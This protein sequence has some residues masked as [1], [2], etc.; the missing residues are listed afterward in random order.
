[1]RAGPL[2]ESHR[3]AALFAPMVA[4]FKHHTRVIRGWV[5]CMSS[6]RCLRLISSTEERPPEIAQPCELAQQ[7]LRAGLLPHFAWRHCLISYSAL[8]TTVFQRGALGRGVQAQ[9]FVEVRVW[10]LDLSM[11]RPATACSSPPALSCPCR[12]SAARYPG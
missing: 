8:A 4:V 6:A 2:A 7:L 10:G 9:V 3:R 12:C 1:M 11:C 5:F